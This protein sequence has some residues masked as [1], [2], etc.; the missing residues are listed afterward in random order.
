MDK[1]CV[2]QLS[3]AELADATTGLIT[4]YNR[5]LLNNQVNTTKISDINAPK[6]RALF[7]MMKTY[8]KFGPT[9]GGPQ[10]GR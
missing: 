1:N 7:E 9:N 10:P 2:Q 5:E 4:R 8:M 6:A 3:F